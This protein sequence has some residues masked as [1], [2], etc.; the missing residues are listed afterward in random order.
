M[1]SRWSSQGTLVVGFLLATSVHLVIVAGYYGWTF[2]A[3]RH[4]GGENV[5]IILYA[6][7]RPAS[8]VPIRPPAVSRAVAPAAAQRRVA[9]QPLAIPPPTEQELGKANGEGNELL[10]GP[11]LLDG[12]LGEWSELATAAA[13]NPR[14]LHAV[15]PFYPPEA[16]QADIEGSVHIRVHVNDAGFVDAASVESAVDSLLATAALEAAW[17]WVFRPAMMGNRFVAVP[18]SIPFRF[19]IVQSR[20]TIE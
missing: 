20:V 13:H 1:Q 17:Q 16:K 14:V 7:M 9:P 18:V 10:A 11:Q 12:R 15:L 4:A 6:E 19:S 3:H 2:V 5:R 8:F